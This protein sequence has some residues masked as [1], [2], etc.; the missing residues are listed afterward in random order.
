MAAGRKT[1]GRQKGVPNKS[2]SEVKAALTEAFDNLGGVQALVTWGTDNLT[3][4]YKLW[5]K[6]LPTE[7]K[8]DVTL[9]LE[10]MLD[11]LSH[12]DPAAPEN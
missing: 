7:V 3:D 8:A 4:F 9:G 5:S 6:M 2:T 12:A 10:D 1:G 11:A